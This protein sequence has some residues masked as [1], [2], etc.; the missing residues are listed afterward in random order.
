M[1]RVKL[2]FLWYDEKRCAYATFRKFGL[3]GDKP[4]FC[5]FIKYTWMKGHSKS[6]VYV[7]TY[8]V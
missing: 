4:F 3:S 7:Y 8:T 2:T 1:S 5:S 6:A